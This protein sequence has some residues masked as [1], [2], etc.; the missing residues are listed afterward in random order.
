MTY[1]TNRNA[2]P[3]AGNAA[4]QTEKMLT[5]RRPTRETGPG[6]IPTRPP[7]LYLIAFIALLF[8]TSL[9]CQLTAVVPDTDA[10]VQQVVA[11]VQAQQPTPALSPTSF[12]GALANVDL[13]LQDQLVGV[14]QQVN[15]S[16]VHIYVYNSFSNQRFPL[17]TGSG[18]VYDSEGHIVTNNHVVTDGD[19]FEVLFS[20]GQRSQAT[21]V[22]ADIDSD[23]AVIKADSLPPAARPVPLADMSQL[24]VGQFVIAIG[25]P[26]GETGSMT[27]GIIS[28]LG[29]SLTSQRA[30]EGGGQYSLPQVIQTDAAINPGNSGGPLL[31]LQG[32]V[33]GVNSAIRTETGTNSGVGFSIP[34]NAVKRIVPSLIE[35]GSYVY[36]YLGIRM[37]TMDPN[38]AE[39]LN[40]P[41]ASGAY[42][43]EVVGNAPAA[44]AG[45]VPSGVRNFSALPGGDLIIAINGSPIASTDDLIS[46]LVFETEVGQTVDL[47][48]VRNGREVAVPLTLGERP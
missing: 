23:L 45:L 8:V 37:Q 30:V 3:D 10:I 11:T 21:M 20:D 15:P 46:Y 12:E 6:R 40:I 35:T 47:T 48:V 9:A 7:K 39:Q 28:G 33:V 29:R 44:R 4:G 24:H 1:P 25:N 19:A 18:F 17:G 26:F 14:Y 27:I 42:V 43:L 5:E 2:T 38:T 32:E 36:P 41:Y 22:G 31:N 16:V 34:V 13:S